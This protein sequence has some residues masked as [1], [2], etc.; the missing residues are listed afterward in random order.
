MIAGLAVSTL[1]CGVGEIT[2]D[3]GFGLGVSC[4][5]TNSPQCQ[6]ISISPSSTVLLLGDTVGL[7]ASNGVSQTDFTWDSPV[8]SIVQAGQPTVKTGFFGYTYSH[9]VVTGNAPGTATIIARRKNYS[10]SAMITVIPASSVAYFAL[11]KSQCHSTPAAWCDPVLPTGAPDTVRVGDTIAVG[12]LISDLG[13][14]PVVATIKWTSSDPS[15]VE[16][17]IAGDQY[18]TAQVV[19]AKALGTVTVKGTVAGLTQLFQVSVLK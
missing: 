6:A 7:N 5:E 2:L 10:G 4:G 1:G 11:K 18:R 9:V 14:R 17:T 8:P 15:I 13:G 3:G 16:P 12:G 19:A